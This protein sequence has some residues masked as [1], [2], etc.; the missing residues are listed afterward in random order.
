MA[1][2]GGDLT[3]HATKKQ[4]LQSY[5]LFVKIFSDRMS[6]ESHELQEIAKE[7]KT[8]QRAEQNSNG[9]VLPNPR[10]YIF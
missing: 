4:E 1:C 3:N 9:R 10:S 6:S 7:D 8:T 5:M 2:W